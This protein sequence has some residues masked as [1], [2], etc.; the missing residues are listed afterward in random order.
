[1]K[2]DPAVRKRKR[3]EIQKQSNNKDTEDYMKVI[4]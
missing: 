3:I 2:C 4:A 1:M